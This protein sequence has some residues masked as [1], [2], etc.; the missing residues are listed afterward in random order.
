M[1]IRTIFAQIY[2]FYFFFRT[3]LRGYGSILFCALFFSSIPFV[4]GNSPTISTFSESSITTNSATVGANLDSYDGSD[5]P[6]ISLYYD[7]EG[8]Y[9]TSRPDYFIPMSFGSDLAF[10]LDA[11][12]SHSIE[13]TAG[14]ISEWRDKSGNKLHVSQT[15]GSNQPVTGNST[16]NGL[17]VVSFDGDDYLKRNS[18][19]IDDYDQTWFLVFEVTT[20]S[21]ASGGE[22]LIGYAGW[23]DGW[24]VRANN[25]SE[26]KGKLYKN[27]GA[28]A[29]TQFVNNQLTGY[30]LVAFSFDRTN[31]NYSSFRNGVVKDS[32]ITDTTALPANQL[33]RIFAG[34]NDSMN[35][36]GQMAEV[37][38]IRTV[39]VSSRER[40]EGY[41]AHKWGISSQLNSSHPYFSSAPTSNLPLREIGIGATGAGAF[42]ESLTG[43][44]PGTTYHYRFLAKNSGGSALTS[45]TTFTTVGPA[46]ILSVFP[47]NV[48][49]SSATIKSMLLS[50]GQEDPTITFYWGDENGSNIALNWDSHQLLSG[51]H[52]VGEISHSVSGLIGGTTYYFTAKAENSGGTVWASVKSFQAINNLPPDDI[53]PPGTLSM[54][55][56]LP[57]G[58]PLLHFSATDPD[59]GSILTFSLS[60]I[61]S[62]T[63]NEL[64]TIDSNGTLR[65]AANFDY[66]NNASSYLVRIRA[67]D[68]LNAFREEEFNIQ[69][70]NV[71]EPLSIISYGGTA[72]QTFNRLEGTILVAT[73]SATDPDSTINYSISG[74]SDDSLFSVDATSGELRFLQAPDFEQRLDSDNGNDYEVTVRA[75]DGSFFSD[76]NFTFD[77]INKEDP[78]EI[79]LIGVTGITGNSAVIEGNLTAFTTGN[80]PQVILYYDDNASYYSSRSDPFTPYNLQGK[81]SVW[82]DANDT[83]SIQH[84]SGAVSQWTDRSGNYHT[85]TQDD[86]S[87]KPTTG[88]HTQ[89]G[90]NVLN[91]DGDDF[92]KRGYS[93]ILAYDH[94]WFIVAR[95]DTGGINHNGDSL[96]S[97]GGGNDGRWELRAH[98]TSNFTTRIV[99][100]SSWLQGTV[101]KIV[102]FDEYHIFTLSFDQ[103]NLRLSNWVD[104]ELRTNALPDPLGITEKQKIVL[105]GSRANIPYAIGGKLAEVVCLR[106]VD[107][108]DRV[109]MEG[110]LAHK[111]DIN[112]SLHSSHPYT[113]SPPTFAQP[114]SE[115]NLGTKPLGN[116]NHTLTGLSP[117][118]TYHYRF[119]GSNG[120]GSSFSSTGS[121]VTTAPAVIQTL[122]PTD[123]TPNSATIRSEVLSTG[124]KL[125][126]HLFLGR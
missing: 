47:S 80:Q 55:E 63:Q 16:Q 27:G 112:S 126:G 18:S 3:L 116:F 119:F 53:L 60:D 4:S 115:V 49:Q 11:N 14:S 22:G 15:N 113:V 20:G 108:T 43:L 110:Y 79:D 57:I 100:D 35:L 69:L 37:I 105:M 25:N 1:P 10:W 74:G 62:T 90:L 106:S 104:G 118:T 76:Q 42:T 77:I 93:N 103:N 120:V 34:H 36:T 66:E 84:N 73:V 51:T 54:L 38:C 28:L 17:N 95:I 30:Q 23:S 59:P 83:S 58:S 101:T 107:P 92:L 52:G 56:N 68:Q 39:S 32:Q 48:T 99:K 102:S 87:S 9:S 85:V 65:N 7:D 2:I 88:I 114:L 91:F 26:F 8:N 72:H 24:H 98:S 82:F 78:P 89:N 64:F 46:E 117:A 45:T 33:I 44:L 109:R 5:L 19:N 124:R 125:G 75:S 40:V 97:Y 21:V 12:D 6:I 29:S 67:T 50:N 13:N 96:I 86:N 123:S 70:Q 71:N 81:I 94:T 41:L 61:N 122:F 111:W 31:T 121:F